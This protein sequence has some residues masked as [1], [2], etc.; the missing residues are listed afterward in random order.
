MSRLKIDGINVEV[1]PDATVLDAA[2]AAGR[3]IPT[4][5]HCREIGPLTACMV[6]V[7]KDIA[8]GKTLPACATPA[9]D[10]MDIVTEDDEIRELR[11]GTLQLLLEEHAGDCEGP[12]MRACPAG[13]RIPRMLRRIQKGALRDAAAIAREDLL[14]PAILG[15]VCA[16]PCERVCRRA[17]YDGALSIRNAHG[18]VAEQC[19]EVLPDRMA[20]SGKSVAVMGEEIDALAA[21]WV[22]AQRGHGCHIYA[23]AERLC[24]SLRGQVPDALLDAELAPLMLWDVEIHLAAKKDREVSPRNTPDKA[25]SLDI[26]ALLARHDAVILTS[27]H[28]EVPEQERLLVIKPEKMPVRAVAAGK[29]AALYV[30]AL[31]RGVSYDGRRPFNSK[32]GPLADDELDH[33]AVFRK[34]RDCPKRA[35]RDGTVPGFAENEPCTQR[36][37]TVPGFAED[38]ARCLHCD[39][40]KPVACKLRQYAVAYGAHVSTT[41]DLPRPKITPIERF[42]DILYESGKC[43]RCGICVEITRKHGVQPGMTFTGRGI[44]SRIRGALGALLSDAL[45]PVAEVCV[46]ACPTGALAFDREEP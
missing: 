43:I 38:A 13:L 14:F 29:R 22:C 42:G 28:V 11:R 7:V 3:A 31:L 17:Q 21:A 32:L 36:D 24:P 45:G 37:G 19:P 26:A 41:R 39:C 33:Y 46:S 35:Q 8:S 18:F 9:K 16:A 44:K 40:L 10:G 30:D 12:C 20:P 5:C 34:T 23:H 27:P 1:G 2:R 6:C 25:V 4:L 15:R